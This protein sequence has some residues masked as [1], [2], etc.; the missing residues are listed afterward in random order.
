MGLYYHRPASEL[1][2]L[3]RHTHAKIH[4]DMRDKSHNLK[5][6]F[7]NMTVNQFTKHG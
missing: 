1:I 3:D 7:S 6:K 4:A 5:S 2:F